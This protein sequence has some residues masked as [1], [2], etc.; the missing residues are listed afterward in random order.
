MKKLFY[1]LPIIFI[2]CATT[3]S[4]WEV[5]PEYIDYNISD[6]ELVALY[7]AF[8]SQPLNNI[9]YGEYR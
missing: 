5:I 4:E 8:N 3:E 1:I 2:G 7:N 9:T 6:K